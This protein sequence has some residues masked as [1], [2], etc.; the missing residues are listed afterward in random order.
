MNTKLGKIHRLLLSYFIIIC[1]A[2]EEEQHVQVLGQ[3]KAHNHEGFEM[4][5]FK[6][7]VYP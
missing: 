5:D 1:W 6:F 4:K 7:C 2:S 3:Y